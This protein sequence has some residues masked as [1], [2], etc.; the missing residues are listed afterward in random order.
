MKE[1]ER[2]RS[3]KFQ[4]FSLQIWLII[5][6]IYESPIM[7]LLFLI[8]NLYLNDFIRNF[9]FFF[10]KKCP[11]THILNEWWTNRS[12]AI[13]VKLYRNRVKSHFLL[14]EVLIQIVLNSDAKRITLTLKVW[15]KSKLEQFLKFHLYIS[16]ASDFNFTIDFLN[17]IKL[18]HFQDNKKRK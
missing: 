2:F 6:Y 16:F 18:D 7:G 9:E 17:S 4:P 14:L 1:I 10:H 5:C 13:W 8:S 11:C 12:F 15:I 3:W